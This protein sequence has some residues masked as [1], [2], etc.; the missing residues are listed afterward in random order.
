MNS[1]VKRVENRTENH[2]GQQNCY[3]M[4]APLLRASAGVMK[5]ILP[6]P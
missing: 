6:S 1:P 4:S 5:R 2:T 3:P